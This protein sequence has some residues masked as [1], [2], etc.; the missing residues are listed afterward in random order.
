PQLKGIGLKDVVILCENMG[1]K[2]TTKGKG[3]VVAQSILPG[4]SFAKGQ[5]LYIELN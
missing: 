5:I 3:K 1:L 4:Q 2:V